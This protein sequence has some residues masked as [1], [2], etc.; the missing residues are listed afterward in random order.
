MKLLWRHRNSLTILLKYTCRRK[1]AI[2][3]MMSLFQTK[4]LQPQCQQTQDK[5]TTRATFVET[6]ITLIITTVISYWRKI[7]IL[8]MTSLFQRKNVPPGCQQSH[9]KLK[10]CETIVDG[11]HEVS[12]QGQDGVQLINDDS[13]N[14]LKT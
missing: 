14:N 11:T 13:F 7:A 4:I 12:G 1:I 9:K 3:Y 2:L 8:Y 6:W 5:H 10:T